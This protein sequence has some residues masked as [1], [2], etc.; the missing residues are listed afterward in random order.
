MKKLDSGINYARYALGEITVIA[1]RDGYVD[2]PPSRLRQAGD[3]PFGS[4][5]PAQVDLV[6]GMLRLSVNAFL[7]IDHG[8]HIL[9]DTGAAN[10]WEPTMGLLPRALA[11]A[12]V[13]RDNITT[14]AVTHTHADH[15]HGLVAADGT[16]AFPN[17][18]RLLIPQEEI[19]MFDSIGRLARFQQ[20]RMPLGDGFKLSPCVTAIAAHG[21][22]VGHTA[23]E[24]SSAGETL[25]IWGDIVHVPSIQFERPELTWEYDTDQDQACVTR[26]RMLRQAAKPNFFVAGSHL[27]FPGI[28][29]ITE[30]DGAFR[31][32]AL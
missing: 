14:V 28:G 20:R 8:Q 2:M 4:D 10:A 16:D 15:V 17:L 6:A 13:A 30:S 25:L 11:E 19:S 18:T 29:K 32:T 27:E 5:L 9:I 24:V 21:H 12:G 7:I 22:E 26:H 1:L 3:R 23:F 31:Y